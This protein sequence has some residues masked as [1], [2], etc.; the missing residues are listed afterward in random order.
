MIENG[1]KLQEEKCLL[2]KEENYKTHRY[3][4]TQVKSRK[5]KKT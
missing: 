5:P 3:S 1:E 4:T 2:P